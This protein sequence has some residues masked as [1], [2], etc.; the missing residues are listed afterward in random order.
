VLD[1]ESAAIALGAS[2]RRDEA[3]GGPGAHALG[4][5]GISRASSLRAAVVRVSNTA[6]LRNEAENGQNVHLIRVDIDPVVEAAA[7]EW[8]GSRGVS[9]LY[10]SSMSGSGPLGGGV[11][12]GIDG[13]NVAGISGA[14]GSSSLGWG[15]MPVHALR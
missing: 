14:L 5:G 12:M 6:G 15:C 11:G 1:R 8:I 13:A 9:E 7:A 2:G 4:G 3:A 10:D